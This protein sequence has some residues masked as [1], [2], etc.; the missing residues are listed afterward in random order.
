MTH[1]ES[2]IDGMLPNLDYLLAEGYHV[3]PTPYTAR[4]TAGSFG[5]MLDATLLHA[6]HGRPWRIVSWPVDHTGEPR[7]IARSRSSTFI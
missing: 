1:Y 7:I 3:S 2:T 5:E 6:G 4:L